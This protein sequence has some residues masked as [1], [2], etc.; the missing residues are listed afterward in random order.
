MTPLDIHIIIAEIARGALE[1]KKI[2]DA[3]KLS[4]NKRIDDIAD[5]IFK[6]TAKLHEEFFPGYIDV[7]EKE[8][9]KRRDNIEQR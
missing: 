3:D 6:D 2:M 9:K 7:Q 8:A 1:I 4:Y 5:L